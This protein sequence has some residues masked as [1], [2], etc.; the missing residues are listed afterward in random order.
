MNRVLALAAV[1]AVVLSVGGA[2]AYFT[3]ETEVRDNV[4][5]AGTVAVSVEPSAAALSMDPVAP[6]QTTTRTVS[7][8]N[9]GLLP[10][11]AV[12]TMEKKAGYVALWNVM[13]CRVVCEGTE[14]YAGPASAMRTAAVRIDPGVTKVLEY[15]ITLSPECDNDV[16]GDYVRTTL[17]V[18][19]EQAY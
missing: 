5:T 10:V 4:I 19:A 13:G 15:G 14:L 2:R 6:G 12:T 18:N 9:T 8:T 17:Y 7:V 3:A 11:D 1:V 16:Q